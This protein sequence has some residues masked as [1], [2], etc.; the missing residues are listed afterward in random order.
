MK[1]VWLTGMPRSGT[2]WVSQ[3]FAASPHIRVK[4]CPLYSYTFKNSMTE[5]DDAS[6]WNSFFKRVYETRD[7]YMDQTYL[8]K[9]GLIPVFRDKDEYPQTLLIKS[10]RHHH[11]TESLLG[12]LPDLRMIAL[13]RNPLA[14]INSW[15]CN[16]TEFPS[17]ADP[18]QEWRSGS[19]RKKGIGEYWGFDDWKSV[20][21]MHLNLENIYSDRFFLHRYEEL[22]RNPYEQARVMFDQIGVQYSQHVDDF[23]RNSKLKHVEHPRSV[24]KTRQ[25]NNKWKTQLDSRIIESILSDLSNTVLEKFIDNHK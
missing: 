14:A 9:E 17:D 10:N 18:L 23:I 19:C 8:S 11:L 5:K 20:T 6:S 22:I 24:F 21:L 1:V 16:P 3:F 12:K 15:I 4:F 7:E 25:N 2:T 13:V